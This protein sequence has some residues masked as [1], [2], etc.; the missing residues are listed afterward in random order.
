MFDIFPVLGWITVGV[1]IVIA[2]AR[3]VSDAARDS[4]AAAGVSLKWLLLPAVLSW[5]LLT[6]GGGE[7]WKT[8]IVLF[9]IELLLAVYILRR[10]RAWILLPRLLAAVCLVWSGG[11]ALH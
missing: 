8:H 6:I 4:R 7:L 11:I 2:R 9:V 5:L 10:Y 1:A 3:R